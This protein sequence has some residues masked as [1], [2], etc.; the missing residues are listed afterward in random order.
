MNNDLLQGLGVGAVVVGI[1]LVVFGFLIVRAVLK[2]LRHRHVVK[3]GISGTAVVKTLRETGVRENN[4]PKIAMNLEVHLPNIPVYVIE[5][6]AVVPLIYYPRIQPG[7]T[8]NVIADTTKL[9]DPNYLGLQF[10]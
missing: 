1:L 4:V 10:E 6:K 3:N 5:K 8:V 2:M 9:D 7:M